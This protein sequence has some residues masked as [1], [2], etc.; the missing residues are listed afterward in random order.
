MHACP[1][2]GM[3]ISKAT[4][5]LC[6]LQ[7]HL[8]KLQMLCWCVE[9][10]LYTVVSNPTPAFILL[11][12]QFMMQQNYCVRSKSFNAE[13]TLQKAFM[14]QV[15]KKLQSFVTCSV[16]SSCN[17]HCLTVS[18]L[19]KQAVYCCS[20]FQSCVHLMYCRC[21]EETSKQRTQKERS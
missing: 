4:S 2:P 9:Y 14:L 3:C 15:A 17:G 12:N 21:E 13:N 8:E 7:I 16:P 6:T 10:V 20:V 18:L 5:Y 1:G 19:C 11:F